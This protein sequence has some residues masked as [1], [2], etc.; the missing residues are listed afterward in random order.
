MLLTLL[1]LA[2][3]PQAAGLADL[4]LPR[5]SRAVQFSSRD[6]SGGN[7]DHGHFTG[8]TEDRLQIM[9]R[10]EGPGRIVRLWSANPQGRLRIELD[11]ET[12][13]DAPFAQMFDG[14]LPSFAA[15]LAGPGGGGFTSYV[16]MPFRERCLVATDAGDALYY[17]VGIERG[18]ATPAA[19]T[20]IASDAF[21][22]A[23]ALAGRSRIVELEGAGEVLELAWTTRAEPAA[24]RDVWLE[25]RA[26]GE[27]LPCLAA[28][29]LACFGVDFEGAAIDTLPLDS[30]ADARVLRLPMPFRRGLRIDLVRQR[31]GAPLP[32]VMG[33]RWR[34]LPEDHGR[35]WLHG[36]FRRA[37]TL[38]GAPFVV[39]DLRGSG[40]LAGVFLQMSGAPGQGI[41][42]LEGDE[43]IVV[44]DEREPTFA[45]TGTEDY[46][47]GA[48]YFRGGRFDRPFFA[49]STLDE[50]RGLVAAAR[51]HVADPIPFA[52]SLR[53]E[54]E[55]G[56]GNDAPGAEYAALAWWYA[57]S[58]QGAAT[59]ATAR[60]AATA[61][62]DKPVPVTL[63]AR[64]LWPD[65]GGPLV[66]LAPGR[67]AIRA[68][69]PAGPYLATPRRAGRAAG[70]S[71]VLGDDRVL[72]LP[73][74][75]ELDELALEPWLPSIR[76]WR[77][78]GPFP[79]RDR[80]GIDEPF[81][82]ERE[83]EFAGWRDVP[84]P[85][86]ASGYVDFSA[87]FPVGS[88]AVAYARTTVHAPEDRDA[89][90]VLGSD[91]AIKVFLDGREVFAKRVHRGASRDQDRLPLRLRRGA[92]VLLFKVEN[93]VGGW[94]LFA[95]LED[96]AGLVYDRR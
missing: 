33:T 73:G 16:P 45:G 70:A 58:P 64:Q 81:A 51:W 94:G 86:A 13:Y 19:A 92:N 32:F 88:P 42:F 80:Q 12:R 20:A 9:A 30:D 76:A 27:P 55:H 15:P 65:A 5:G 44:D 14:S 18:D 21:E 54:L 82:P 78:A 62:F 40:H 8:R 31:A 63:A 17:H 79:A 75:I 68:T 36:G 1:A 61:P 71:L 26:D 11:G 50:R 49:V 38:F 72:A 95:R 48:W 28:P 89:L 47:S 34:R 7:T 46:F 2:P 83:A 43:R 91:D 6:P 24:W 67:H 77:I 35:L 53:F 29:L 85:G 84:D 69:L 60:Q 10:V 57:D 96:D 41:T 66:S 4:P 52:R 25:V 90:L 39:A 37:K 59:D 93:Y 87:F 56:G 23:G 22:S 74:P 3:L